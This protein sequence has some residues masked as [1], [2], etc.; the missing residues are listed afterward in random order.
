MMVTDV[1]PLVSP[2]LAAVS[3]TRPPAVSVSLQPTNVAT[4]LTAE[5]GLTEVQKSVPAFADRVTDAELVVTTLPKASTILATGWA[6]N[7]VAEAVVAGDVVKIT[8]AAAAGVMAN[9]GVLA[10]DV[11]P[12]DVAVTT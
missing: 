12:D 8:L 6:A 7:T 1:V 9:A 10:A 2:E 3:V 4:P 11:N 5:S